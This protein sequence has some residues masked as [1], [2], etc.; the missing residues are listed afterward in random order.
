MNRFFQFL[1]TILLILFVILAIYNKL[2]WEDSIKNPANDAYLVEC[3]FNLGIEKHEVK[4]YQFSD[5]Y[6]KK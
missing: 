5:R 2:T 4:Q 1:V 6:L 3:A